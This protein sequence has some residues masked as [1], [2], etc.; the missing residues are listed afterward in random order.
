MLTSIL[1]DQSR[2]SEWREG[3]KALFPIADEFD[4]ACAIYAFEADY[5]NG[6]TPRQSYDTFD[7][8][9]KE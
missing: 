9:T 6:L 4:L 8:W 3:L 1:S 7:A 5:L 2:F